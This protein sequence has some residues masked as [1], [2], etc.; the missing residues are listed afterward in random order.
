MDKEDIE[1]EIQN[2]SEKVANL[3]AHSNMTYEEIWKEIL[4]NLEPDD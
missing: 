1:V 2:I 4:T 3:S